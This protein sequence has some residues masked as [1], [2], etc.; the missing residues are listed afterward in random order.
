MSVAI[1]MCFHAELVITLA[2]LWDLSAVVRGSLRTRL[3][4]T[5][6]NFNQSRQ[7]NR[8]ADAQNLRGF[9]C[10]SHTEPRRGL[11]TW[12][13]VL[14]PGPLSPVA[15]RRSCLPPGWASSSQ[16]CIQAV[17][18]PEALFSCITS[19]LWAKA[20]NGTPRPHRSPASGLWSVV[21]EMNLNDALA[22][23]RQI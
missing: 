15:S 18:V 23:A 10:E 17:S 4:L 2:S 1:E 9:G 3:G 13:L 8:R 21:N 7:R 16:G 11:H 5:S 19:V 14:G 6:I 12:V 22:L 20:A